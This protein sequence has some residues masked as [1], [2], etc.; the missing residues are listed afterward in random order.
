MHMYLNDQDCVHSRYCCHPSKEEQRENGVSGF[1]MGLHRLLPFLIPSSHPLFP[2]M[3]FWMLLSLTYRFPYYFS[4]FFLVSFYW[5]L[6]MFVIP[7]FSFR[8][9]GV[10]ITQ[11]L[12]LCCHLIFLSLSPKKRRESCLLSSSACIRPGSWVQ[13]RTYKSVCRGW[14]WA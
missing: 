9:K 5:W 6:L 4:N 10:S 7:L 2:A 3:H 11:S 8:Y 14:G 12:F 13:R 1:F